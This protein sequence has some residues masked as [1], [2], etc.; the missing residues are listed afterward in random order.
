[1]WSGRGGRP[2]HLTRKATSAQLT[3]EMTLY[4]KLVRFEVSTEV[5]MKDAVVWNV[6]PCGSCKNRLVSEALRKEILC[7]HVA[8]VLSV[9]PFLVPA[10]VVPSLTILVTLIMEAI[11]SSESQ[12]LQVPHCITPQKTAFLIVTTFSLQ[13]LN[14][15]P[16]ISFAVFSVSI[17]SL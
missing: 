9:L 3:P 6:T 1:M 7:A 10:N 16:L 17:V 15:A 14:H 2:S 8:F 4:S 5:A 12:F 11:H 13:Y